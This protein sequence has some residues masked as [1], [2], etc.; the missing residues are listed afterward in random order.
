MAFLQIIGI[1]TIAWIAVSALV[2][3]VTAAAGR[4]DVRERSAGRRTRKP[5]PPRSAPQ[6]MP[7]RAR[8]A[9]TAHRVSTERDR[10]VPSGVRAAIR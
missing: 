5:A 7:S 10:P 9:R 3:A 1:V 8:L 2:V 4:A 6:G